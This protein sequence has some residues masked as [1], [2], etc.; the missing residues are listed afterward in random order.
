LLHH[1]SLE[2]QEIC[3]STYVFVSD[4]FSDAVFS[5][6]KQSVKVLYQLDLAK[7]AQTSQAS[8]N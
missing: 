7:R 6:A 3:F 1:F 4:F 8:S 5:A 2:G